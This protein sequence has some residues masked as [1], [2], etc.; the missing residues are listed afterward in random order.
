MHQALAHS[1][2]H[3]LADHLQAV[4]KMSGEFS[5]YFESNDL[6]CRWAYLAGLWH[7]LGSIVL[8]FSGMCGYLITLTH[9]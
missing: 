1:G 5:A 3:L 8:A 2:D 7:D 6:P 9:T 4:A